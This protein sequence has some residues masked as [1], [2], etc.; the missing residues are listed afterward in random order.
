MSVL[1]YV[2][3]PRR[4][5]CVIFFSP[6]FHHSRYTTYFYCLPSLKLTT[7]HLPPQAHFLAPL[8]P[9]PP[10]MALSSSSLPFGRPTTTS[11][12]TVRN[13]RMRR[14]EPGPRGPMASGKGVVGSQKACVNNVS[15]VVLPFVQFENYGQTHISSQLAV[16]QVTLENHKLGFLQIFY[17]RRCCRGHAPVTTSVGPELIGT[18][19]NFAFGIERAPVSEHAVKRLLF[20]G[21][22]FDG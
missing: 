5:F 4:C 18:K 2:R 13:E 3:Q 17:D 19:S 8:S 11:A 15:F 12:L 9:P 14:P 22:D 1:F 20:L 7:A 21:C 16:V 10:S 6:T